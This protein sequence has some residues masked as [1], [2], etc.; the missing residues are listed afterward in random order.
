MRF[1][2]YGRE[3]DLI[4]LLSDNSLHTAQDLADRLDITR[5]NLYNYL[6][7]LRECGFHV[8]KSGTAYRLD[9]SSPFFRRLHENIALNEGEA[10]FILKQLDGL[11]RQGNMADTIRAK[12][13]RQFNLADHSD[14]VL[15]QRINRNVTT[16]KAAMAQ[17]QMVTLR[18]Y[19]SPHSATVSDRI[20]EPFLLMNDGRDVRCHELKTHE[21]KT[22]RISRMGSVEL[23]DVPW[24][25]ESQH[26]QVYTDLFMFSG[27]ERHHIVLS[28]GQLSHN[29]MAEEYPAAIGSMRPDGD[30]GRWLFEADVVS[31]L[32][33]G[34]FVLGLYDDI[35][36]LGDDDFRRFVHDKIDHFH[37]NNVQSKQENAI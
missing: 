31:L 29:L 20:V 11:E 23:L 5:R 12:L 35:R 34:R 21:N 1:N 13:T 18:N 7:Y 17:K 4:L 25:C 2:K 32:G 28:L 37:S 15:M 16:L 36:I 30:S 19:S 6:E 27:E 33:I 8:I 22:F 9:R 10:A 24:I 26:K 14:A 3:L